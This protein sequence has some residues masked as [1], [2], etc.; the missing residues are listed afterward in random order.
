MPVV[1]GPIG[2][3]KIYYEAPPADRLEGEM[4]SFIRWWEKSRNEAES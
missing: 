1:S 3:E 2:R 4:K